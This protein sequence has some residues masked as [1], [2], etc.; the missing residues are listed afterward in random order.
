VATTQTGAAE[1]GAADPRS[2]AAGR[3]RLLRSAV[4]GG[5]SLLLAG[6]AHTLG[7]GHLPGPGALA[8]TAMVLGLVAT[9]ATARRC[10]FPV[11]MAMLGSEQVLLHLWFT[12]ALQT[13]AIC[14]MGPAGAGGGHSGHV[15]VADGCLSTSSPA[16]DGTG[17]GYGMWVAHAIAIILTAWLLARGEAWWWRTVD[18]IV[19]AAATATRP[20]ETARL[21]ILV[22]PVVLPHQAELSPAAPR[23][24]PLLI[25]S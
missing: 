15:M 2:P 8:G 4:L 5:S 22:R 13:E 11:L 10:R 21:D 23:G 3:P 14:V 18:Q 12:A 17:H 7:G 1:L 24:P 25:A 9:T 20:V 19:R 16:A 6:L